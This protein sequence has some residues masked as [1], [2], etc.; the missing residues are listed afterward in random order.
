MTGKER[1]AAIIKLLKKLT[2]TPSSIFLILK[3]ETEFQ[4]HLQK[5]YGKTEFPT[6]DIRYFLK[7]GETEINNYSFLEGGSLVTD[8]ALLKSLAAKFEACDYL[9]I[10]SW[11]GESIVNV[12]DVKNSQCVSINLS[13][14]EIIARGFPEK[15]ANEHSVLMKGRENIQ[16]IYADSQEF[17]FASLNKKF[18]L[19][20]VDGDHKYEAVKSD[21]ENVY[22]L[23]KNENSVIVWHDYGFDPV[24]PRHS[25][26]SAILDGMPADTHKHI[27]HVSNTMCAIYTRSN[28]VISFIENDTEKA[29][30]VFNL[31]LEAADFPPKTS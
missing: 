7:K 3:D 23:L 18:D 24:T 6:I 30:K 27:Y 14:E 15:Y 9:E 17:D 26:I 4:K 1:I 25:V 11:R 10:G 12:A 8:L 21:T 2:R 19:I 29:N 28:E 20:F 22:K 16:S 13:P 5:K 31:K